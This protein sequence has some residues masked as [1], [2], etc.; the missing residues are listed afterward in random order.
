M[1][2]VK[3]QE[4]VINRDRKQLIEIHSELVKER[5]LLDVWFNKYLDIFSDKMTEVS[6]ADPVWKLYDNK[7]K[8]YEKVKANLK[9]VE[10]HINHV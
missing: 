9:T 2:T 7:Y 6:K 5:N 8:L 4:A 10:Y 1:T 3:I